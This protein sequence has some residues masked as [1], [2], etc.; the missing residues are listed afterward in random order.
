MV[1]VPPRDVVGAELLVAGPVGEVGDLPGK[2]A[3]PLG[4]G[5]VD[6]RN[7]QA[8]EVEVDGDAEVDVVVHD[9]LVVADRRV[10]VRE[11]ADRRRRARER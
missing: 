10:D 2:G 6:D 5:V 7:D 1:N 9:Q 11:L 3:Q 4:V 8:L